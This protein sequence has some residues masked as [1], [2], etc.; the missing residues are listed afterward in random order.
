MAAEMKRK[1]ATL[2][3]LWEEYRAAHPYGY[4]YTWLEIWAKVD[5]VDAAT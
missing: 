2:L 5:G 3:L 1:G 4:G